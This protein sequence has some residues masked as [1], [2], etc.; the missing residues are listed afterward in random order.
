MLAVCLV[1][2]DG[3]FKMDSIAFEL[4]QGLVDVVKLRA[5]HG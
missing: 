1:V 4:R 5:Q 3:A 2:A